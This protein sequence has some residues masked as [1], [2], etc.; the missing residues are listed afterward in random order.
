MFRYFV[1]EFNIFKK[2]KRIESCQRIFS[3]GEGLTVKP[4]PLQCPSD[5]LKLFWNVCSSM[6]HPLMNSMGHF[7]SKL[8][9][10]EMISKNNSCMKSSYFEQLIGNYSSSYQFRWIIAVWSIHHIIPIPVF[11]LCSLYVNQGEN[12]KS[13]RIYNFKM[14]HITLTTWYDIF[15]EEGLGTGHKILKPSEL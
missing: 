11:L 6:R 12:S 3:L 7:C 5:L 10:F 14:F 4:S 2:K 13:Q 9:F 8:N 1:H 15:P